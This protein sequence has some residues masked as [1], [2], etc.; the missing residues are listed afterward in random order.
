[1]IKIWVGDNLREQAGFTA[2]TNILKDGLMYFYIKF[3][4]KKMP[5]FF[6]FDIKVFS[7]HVH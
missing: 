5:E 7:F 1:M 3:F 4:V 6:I 2:N